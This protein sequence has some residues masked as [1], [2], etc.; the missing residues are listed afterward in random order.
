MLSTHARRFASPCHCTGWSQVIRHRK[1]PCGVAL[2]RAHPPRRRPHPQ[3]APR[4]HAAEVGREAPRL[5]GRARRAGDVPDLGPPPRRGPS[6]AGQVV[7]IRAERCFCCCGCAFSSWATQPSWNRPVRA[8]SRRNASFFCVVRHAKA[9]GWRMRFSAGRFLSDWIR[10]WNHQLQSCEQNCL[11]TQM[12]LCGRHSKTTAGGL[13]CQKAG[14]PPPTGPCR[15]RRAE[16]TRSLR[17]DQVWPGVELEALLA[18]KAGPASASLA[19]GGRWILKASICDGANV[20]APP[21]AAPA[22]SK[23]CSTRV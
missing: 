19:E 14:F 15:K 11:W 3:G 1:T 21:R 22:H 4:V 18:E 8:D 2:T 10:C 6:H 13:N 17:R 16:L 20:R 7:I 5:R 12:R 23:T 9:R